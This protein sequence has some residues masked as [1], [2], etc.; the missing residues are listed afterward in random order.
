[1]NADLAFAVGIS[2]D[3][4]AERASG[5]LITAYLSPQGDGRPGLCS[6]EAQRI[7]GKIG[8]MSLHPIAAAYSDQPLSQ[9]Q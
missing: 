8:T 6:G 1:M 2:L 5:T 4:A 7:S 3:I 9:F